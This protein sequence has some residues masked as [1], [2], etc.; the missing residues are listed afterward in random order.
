M[1]EKKAWLNCS[2]D[3]LCG[4]RLIV[5]QQKEYTSVLHLLRPAAV[6]MACAGIMQQSGY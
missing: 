5:L 3:L 4:F 1:A 2:R 6:H